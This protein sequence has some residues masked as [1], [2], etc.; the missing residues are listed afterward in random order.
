MSTRE[1]IWNVTGNVVRF[2][3]IFAGEAAFGTSKTNAFQSKDVRLGRLFEIVEVL[4]S[5]VQ[6]MYGA[7]PTVLIGETKTTFHEPVEIHVGHVREERC[8][9]ILE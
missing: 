4:E 6:P 1:N 7:G 2:S 8:A 9:S 3:E 5:L